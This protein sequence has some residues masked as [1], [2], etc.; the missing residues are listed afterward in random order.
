M[1]RPRRRTAGR[2]TCSDASGALDADGIALLAFLTLRITQGREDELADAG[3]GV[4]SA[5]D[6][7]ADLLAL[8]LIAQ[9]RQDEAREA[10][11]IIRPV[12]RDFFH[13]C[14]SPCAG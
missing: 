2:P 6:V 5:P 11:R 12:R 3:R 14:S 1:T 8:P 4:D 9:G 10:R 13:C 7:I